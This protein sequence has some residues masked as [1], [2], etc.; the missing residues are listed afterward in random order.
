MLHST[1]PLTSEQK[2]TAG[3]LKIECTVRL[4]DALCIDKP[5]YPAWVDVY[6]CV[7]SFGSFQR[8]L[9]GRGLCL[10]GLQPLPH[11]H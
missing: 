1:K 2:N 5:N 8:L 6:L 11:L 7:L 10:L 3:P 4:R 9:K